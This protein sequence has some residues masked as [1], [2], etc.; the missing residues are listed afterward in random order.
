ML[1]ADVYLSKEQFEEMFDHTLLNE[2]REKYK[3]HG[4]FLTPF[5]KMVKKAPK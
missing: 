1:Y 3:A 2:C 5:E 4:A